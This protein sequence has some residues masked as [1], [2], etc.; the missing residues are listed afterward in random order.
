[1]QKYIKTAIIHQYYL[2]RLHGLLTLIF[3]IS[4]LQINKRMINTYTRA[5]II[6]TQ[7]PWF[8]KVLNIGHVHVQFNK[9][10]AFCGH[11]KHMQIG[12]PLNTPIFKSGFCIW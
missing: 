11:A 9:L 7:R 4:T 5:H 1:M 2:Y 6:G 10:C 8:I 12:W 3:E